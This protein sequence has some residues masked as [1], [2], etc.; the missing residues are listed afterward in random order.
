MNQFLVGEKQLAERISI[1]PV[2][3]AQS[4]AEHDNILYKNGI[5]KCIKFI[6]KYSSIL[7]STSK[8]FSGMLYPTLK[9][10]F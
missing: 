9:L 4:Q 6:F 1:P 8:S 7:S 5:L 10:T 2:P 3:V